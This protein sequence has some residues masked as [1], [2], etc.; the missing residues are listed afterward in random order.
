MEQ[1]LFEKFDGAYVTDSMLQEA[2][3]LF[4]EHYGIWGEH[5][6][7][8]LGRFAEAGKIILIS[9]LSRFDHIQVVR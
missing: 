1:R 2:A 9:Y 5:A 6:T 8:K 4:S 3:Q 7:Q